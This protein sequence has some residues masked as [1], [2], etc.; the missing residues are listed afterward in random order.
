MT[1]EAEDYRAAVEKYHGG[2]ELL[3][4]VLYRVCSE[5]P[6]HSDVPGVTAKV[7]LIGRAYQTGI[8][9]QM[10]SDGTQ[11][12]AMTRLANYLFAHRQEVDALIAPFLGVEGRVDA[13]TF[14]GVAEAHTGLVNLLKGETRGK[15]QSFVSK[16]LHFHA[17]IVPIYDALAVEVIRKF[18]LA[19]S[20]LPPRTG[21]ESKYAAFLRRF[22][23]LASEA[24]KTE[25]GVTSKRLDQYLLSL[26]WRPEPTKHNGRLEPLP[27]LPR[28]GVLS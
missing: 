14:A 16:Y 12:A 25:A 19:E 15:A 18:D 22:V 28:S 27:T 20:Q 8:E 2:W 24:S 1:F 4:S 23:A 6:S 10:K 9:R 17:P 5:H 26:A 21:S 7:F 3:D 13:H 11:A